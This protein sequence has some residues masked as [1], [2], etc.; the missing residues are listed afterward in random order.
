MTLPAALPLELTLAFGPV[1]A[2]DLALFAAS[3][4]DHNPLH[5]DAD[6][7][8]LAGFERPLVHGMLTMACAARLFTQAFGAERVRHLQTRF[9]GTAMLGDT[10][11]LQARLDRQEQGQAHYTVQVFRSDGR[12]V[13]TGRATVLLGQS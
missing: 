6:L 7:A 12:E 4:G 1:R 3:S 9:T 2:I 11:R 5:L 13:A 10:L 8:R